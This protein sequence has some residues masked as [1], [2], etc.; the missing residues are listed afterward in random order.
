MS[1]L[2]CMHMPVFLIR[3]EVVSCPHLSSYQRSILLSLFYQ[4][5]TEIP[6]K[7]NLRIIIVSSSSSY[8]RVSARRK[9]PTVQLGTCS[10]LCN[11][12]PSLRSPMQQVI[13]FL[14][15]PTSAAPPP[16]PSSLSR[17]KSSSDRLF[18][19]GIKS[20][21]IFSSRRVKMQSSDFRTPIMTT[22]MSGKKIDVIVN[23][24]MSHRQTRQA[25]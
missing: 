22:N 23:D 7:L 12:W 10:T 15:N 24:L 9:L 18:I 2:S 13:N 1:L 11:F 21:R 17:C 25:N 5:S 20:S 16:P 14:N 3:V 6:F 8:Q 4:T 19:S